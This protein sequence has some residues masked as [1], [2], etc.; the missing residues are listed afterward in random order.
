M[1]SFGERES[2]RTHIQWALGAP[3]LS[4]RQC[5]CCRSERGPLF[6]PVRVWRLFCAPPNASAARLSER[7]KR[8]GPTEG[9]AKFPSHSATPAAAHELHEPHTHTNTC[10]HLARPLLAR[11]LSPAGETDAWRASQL[12]SWRL[13]A[14]RG[15]AAATAAV[16]A[17]THTPNPH[18]HT[19]TNGASR[20]ARTCA[21]RPQ[22]PR[23]V[24]APRARHVGWPMAAPAPP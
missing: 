14:R 1:P 20:R 8:T 15:P 9:L 5:G 24:G 10:P 18:T 17:H 19:H 23:L 3:A 2:E 7:P 6:G 16:T 13:A 12:T 22:Q 21:M 11:S 4:D